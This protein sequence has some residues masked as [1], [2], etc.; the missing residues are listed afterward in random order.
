M[1]NP[2]PIHLKIKEGM[3]QTT[4][5]MGFGFGLHL[6][7]SE[8]NVEPRAKPIKSYCINTALYGACNKKHHIQHEDKQAIMTVFSGLAEL[9]CILGNEVF[10]L[11]IK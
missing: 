1:H 6:M 3:I 9:G 8:K 10:I 4:L 7:S 5:N 11:P 2:H